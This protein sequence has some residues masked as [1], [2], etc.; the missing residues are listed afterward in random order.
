MFKKDEKDKK[1]DLAQFKSEDTAVLTL[2]SPVDGSELSSKITLAS[3]ESKRM[4]EYIRSLSDFTDED[5]E[6]RGL[7]F[8][9]NATVDWTDVIY[10]GKDLQCTQANVRMLYAENMWILEQVN[11]FLLNRANFMKALQRN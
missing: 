2:T 10:D 1:V 4:R 8:L 7:E 5:S 9:V 6:E 3:R 11:S